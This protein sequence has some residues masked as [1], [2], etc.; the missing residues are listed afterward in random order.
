M[1]QVILRSSKAAMQ[2]QQ[3]L[4]QPPIC[5]YEARRTFSRCQ[6]RQ[7]LKG[8]RERAAALKSNKPAAQMHPKTEMQKMMQNLPK[9]Q[10]PRDL[11]LLPGQSYLRSSD[12]A[13]NVLICAAQILS[14][15][16]QA[17]N[18]LH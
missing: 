7:A 15:C 11:G 10:L 9:E 18:F 6:P 14:S 5:I 17:R 3:F 2:H 4:W 8:N 12:F 13:S 16:Q 1:A